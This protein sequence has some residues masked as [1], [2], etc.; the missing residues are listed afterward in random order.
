MAASL[1]IVSDQVQQSHYD[2]ITFINRYIAQ[3]NPPAPYVS[4][5]FHKALSEVDGLNEFGDPIY[6]LIWAGRAIYFRMGRIR[7]KYPLH[8]SEQPVGWEVLTG[9]YY[10]NG[11]YYQ[12][13]GRRGKRNRAP[14]TQ[15]LPLSCANNRSLGPGRFIYD[16]LDIGK[17]RFIIEE[18]CHPDIACKDW[19]KNRFGPHPRT[20]MWTD[21]LGERPTRG[22]YRPFLVVETDKHE[23]RPPDED[24]LNW[25]RCIMW[26]RNQDPVLYNRQN[27][28]PASLLESNLRKRYAQY[29]EFDAREQQEAEERT[30]DRFISAWRRHTLPDANAGGAYGGIHIIHNDN[31]LQKD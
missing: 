14:E 31:F 30:R 20:G 19:D 16:V 2:P 22:L 29:M 11:R 4:P 6:R 7:I 5:A 18:W 28:P 8:V 3:L 10:R 26:L 25:F 21:I 17:P 12:Y 9:R 15:A 27:P 13:P 24:T 23:Y 1:K